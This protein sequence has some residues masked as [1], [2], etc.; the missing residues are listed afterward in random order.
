MRKLSEYKIKRIKEMTKEG[1]DQRTIAEALNV[2]QW[3]VQK[4]SSVKV[5]RG[6]KSHLKG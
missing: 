3:T 1:I 4:Y 6:K 5:G 2:S